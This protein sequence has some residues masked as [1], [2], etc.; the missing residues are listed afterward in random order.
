MPALPDHCLLVWRFARNRQ[1][2]P[3]STRN[4]LRTLQRSAGTFSR[5]PLPCDAVLV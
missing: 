1:D 2:S 5:N 4:P 3:N